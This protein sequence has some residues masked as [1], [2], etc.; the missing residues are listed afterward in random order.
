ML[1]CWG[2]ERRGRKE[3]KGREMGRGR[4][5]SDGREGETR[6]KR[7]RNEEKEKI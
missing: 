6:S 3:K 7:G 1:H 2:S 4:N 5:E